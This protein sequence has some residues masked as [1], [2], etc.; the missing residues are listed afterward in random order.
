MKDGKSQIDKDGAFYDFIHKHI[1]RNENLI[2]NILVKKQ[3]LKQARK[4]YHESENDIRKLY[5]ALGQNIQLDSDLEDTSNL[6]EVHIDD[7]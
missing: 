3:T 2:R 4:L 6:E 1:K 7:A 5:A